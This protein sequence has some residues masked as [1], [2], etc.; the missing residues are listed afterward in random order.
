M[1]RAC[2]PFL[3]LPLSSE[4]R[5]QSEIWSFFTKFFFFS[6]VA[7]YSPNPELGNPRKTSGQP[8]TGK[9]GKG[10]PQNGPRFQIQTGAR[11]THA[12]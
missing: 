8:V 2:L 3:S 7:K 5:H 9:G 4:S 1:R 6:M 12:Q 11:H 10:V